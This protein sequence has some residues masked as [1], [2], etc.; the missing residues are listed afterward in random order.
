MTRSFKNWHK[1]IT[2]KKLKLSVKDEMER[3]I[4]KRLRAAPSR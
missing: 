1:K 2:L 3:H 4:A